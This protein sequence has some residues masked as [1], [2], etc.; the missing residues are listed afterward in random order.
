MFDL[1]ERP[2]FIAGGGHSDFR[3]LIMPMYSRFVGPS[4]EENIFNLYGVSW[5]VCEGLELKE[6][7]TFDRTID[8]HGSF[9]RVE[10][11][12]V[13]GEDMRVR[14]EDHPKR[15]CRGAE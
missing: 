3:L 8:E 7:I 14:E 10:E 13:S 6:L 1:E 11:C 9:L 4:G 15:W 2:C 12:L 5:L